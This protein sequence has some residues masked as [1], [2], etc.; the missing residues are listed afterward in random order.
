MSP[1]H[2]YK[3]TENTLYHLQHLA[4]MEASGA[5][6]A[7]FLQGQLTCDIRNLTDSKAGIAAYCTPKGRVITTLLVVKTPTAF[8]LILPGSLLNKVLKRLQMYILRSK[9]RLADKSDS[10]FLTGL[11]YSTAIDSLPTD[12]FQCQSNSHGI[13]VR[14]PS[15]ACRYLHIGDSDPAEESFLNCCNEG[16]ESDWRYQ[17]ISSGFPWFNLEQSEKY[18]PQMLNLDQLGGISFNKG[19]YTG[20]EIVARTHYLG[21]AKRRMYLAECEG[22]LSKDENLPI[23]NAETQEKA[24]E[25]LTHEVAGEHTRLLLVLQTVDAPPKNLILDDATQRSLTLI[26]Y[27]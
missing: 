21:E 19:C 27:Q 22:V 15:K 23:K 24:G 14:L 16:K 5:D 6:A 20:Q 25:I 2:L 1:D 17:D 4:V 26:P 10:L 9:V 7:Q 8:L 11:H 13:T 12:A 18:I 3:P